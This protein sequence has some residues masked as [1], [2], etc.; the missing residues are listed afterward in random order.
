MCIQYAALGFEPTTSWTWVVSINHLNRVPAP[1]ITFVERGRGRG[2]GG[3]QVVGVFAFYS[4]NPI[5]IYL[6]S[7][8]NLKRPEMANIKQILFWP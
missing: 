1:V 7:T 5:W 2:R 8:N 3:G 4:D 6:K